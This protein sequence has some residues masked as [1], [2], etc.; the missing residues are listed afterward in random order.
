MADFINT[1]DALGDDAV[2]DS[3]VDRSITEFKD[4]VL[5]E[6]GNRAFQSCSSLASVELPNCTNIGNYAFNGCSALTEVTDEQFT[7]LTRIGSNAFEGTKVQRISLSKLTALYGNAFMSLTSLKEIRLPA[8]KSLENNC[9]RQCYGGLKLV[10]LGACTKI[11]SGA[12]Y[13][14]EYLDKVVLRSETMCTLD[15][16]NSLCGFSNSTKTYPKKIYVPSALVEPYKTATNWSSYADRI[17]ALEDYTIDGTITGDLAMYT[18]TYDLDGVTSSN[19]YVASGST[20]HT[21]LSSTNE[22]PIRLVSVSMGGVD[23]TSNVYNEE[24]GEISIPYVTGNITVYGSTNLVEYELLYELP[25][26]KTFNGTSDYVDTGIKLFDTAKD[27]T[28][29]CVADFSALNTANETLFHCMQES[30]PYPGL[31]VDRNKNSNALR[32]IHTRTASV[33][34]L[35]EGVENIKAL[36]IR[37]IAGALDCVFYKNASGNIVEYNPNASAK[38][39]AITQNLILGAYQ[40]TAGNKGRYYNGTISRFEVYG[41]AMNNAEISA[42]L[43]D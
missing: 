27:F 6:V 24:T 31:A 11:A 14:C 5:T 36:A 10:D 33:E 22:T 37:Y 17:F 3:I 13:G 42:K 26:A 29:V 28:I 2:A 30:S 32:I 1:I 7:S 40:D 41:S 38:Y 8:I 19:T 18:V 21:V 23:I 12:F 16:T 9:F 39:T 34:P 25:Q 43:Y 35:I 4:D 20:Y 15:G